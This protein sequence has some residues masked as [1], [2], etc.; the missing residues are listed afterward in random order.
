MQAPC[1]LPLPL[2][3]FPGGHLGWVTERMMGGG[4]GGGG[5]GD[6]PEKMEGGRDGM[7]PKGGVPGAGPGAGLCADG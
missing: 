1:L 6:S 4:G 7:A 5:G 3:H 2:E